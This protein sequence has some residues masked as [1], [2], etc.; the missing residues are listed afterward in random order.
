MKNSKALL[1]YLVSN[2]QLKESRSEIES[3]AYTVLAHF[4]QISRTKVLSESPLN[5]SNEQQALIDHI[6]QRINTSEPVQYITGVSNFYG[7]DF[8]VNP[9]VLIPRPETEEIIIQVLDFLKTQP[10][11]SEIKILD[12]GT[13]SGCIPITLA[14]EVPNANVFATDI[15]KAAL[16]VARENAHQHRAPITFYLH[17]ILG[18][19]PLP[20][21][22]FD[23]FVS[24]P[25]YITESEKL[26]MQANVLNY[27][28]HQALFVPD[29][30]AL[31]FYK[32]IASLGNKMI[33][34]GGLLIFEINERYGEAVA[35]L[36][37]SSGYIGVEIIKDLSQKQR[38]VKGIK[39]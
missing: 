12:V 20:F 25:P 30:N 18:I 28:P 34:S 22:E 10:I 5:W 3:I 9:H 33:R 13:G 16:T 14:L 19:E 29:D 23:V 27:E 26:N 6:I 1:H 8:K 21:S 35:A 39:I 38:M 11:Q 4:F 37:N 7:R 15:S 24:N 17:D 36:L 2:I 32:Q 31:V